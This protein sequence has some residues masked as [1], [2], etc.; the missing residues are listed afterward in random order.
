[1]GIRKY[2]GLER[3]RFT[4]YTASIDVEFHIWDAVGQRPRTKKV[5]GRLT[6][7]SLQG[8]R[9]QTNH[10]LIEGHHLFLDDDVAGNTPLIL[11]LPEESEGKPRTLQARALWYN[12]SASARQYSFDVGLQ[13]INLSPD[14]R[15]YLEAILTA[16]TTSMASSSAD[17]DES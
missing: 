12:R 1:M 17:A 14:Q 16:A 8:A 9:L 4:R 7:I 10:T 15:Q 5:P 2:L 11:S 3:R 6:D 13:F